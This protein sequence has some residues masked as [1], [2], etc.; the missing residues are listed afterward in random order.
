M[1]ATMDEIAIRRAQAGDAGA[2]AVVHVAAWR[3]TYAGLMPE[4]LLGALSV[5]ERTSRWH[6][7]LTTPDRSRESAAFVTVH[8]AQ[9]VVGFGSCGRQPLADLVA[10]GF[11]GEFSALYVLAAHQRRGLGRR[12]MVLMAEDLMARKVRGAALWVLRENEPARRFYEALGAKVVGRRVETVGEHVR[13]ERRVQG[14]DELHEVAYGWP[15]L[16]VLAQR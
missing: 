6:R 2:I 1:A 9:S 12:L 15:D 16:A 14:D 4:P 13:G 5:E 8:A 10:G 3:E 11:A 7:I